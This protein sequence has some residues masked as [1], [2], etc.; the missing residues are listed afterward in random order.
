MSA[1]TFP[2]V[3]RSAVLGGASTERGALIIA[4]RLGLQA[5]AVECWRARF[6]PDSYLHGSAW[7][8]GP[9]L[10]RSY[11]MRPEASR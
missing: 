3:Y 7:F 1:P 6:V 8:V 11:G 2:V 10:A 4:R 9:V 5:P